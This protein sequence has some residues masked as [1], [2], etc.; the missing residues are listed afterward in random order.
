MLAPRGPRARFED[1][2]PRGARAAAR[3]AAPARAA[4][5]REPAAEPLGAHGAARAPT[6]SAGGS[7]SCRASRTSPGSSSA[8]ACTSAWSRPSRPRPSCAA[9]A[10]RALVQRV[11]RAARDASAASGSRRSAP[12]CSSCSGS[13]TTT[14][15]GRRPAGR[16]GARAARLRGRRRADE[17][18]ARRRA[19]CSASRQFTLYGDAR[20]GNRP[21]YVAAARPEHAEPLYERFCER[22]GRRSAA[23]F[24]AHM[25]GRAGQR[26]PGDA[27]ARGYA[28]GCRAPCRPTSASSAAS[29]PSRRRSR[30]PTAA[31]PR[32][33]RPSSS[34]RACGS[35]T[36]ARTSARPASSTLVPRP[37]VER[38]HV[39][40]R[41]PRATANGFELFGYV[42]FTPGD[43]RTTSR[44]TSTRW[45]DFTDETAERQPRLADGP[46]RGGRRRLARRG[47]RR[48]RR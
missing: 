18:A 42:S 3:R 48:W 37:H 23:R 20:K 41:R 8:R 32:P 15:G 31:G 21:A 36:R 44:R 33:C 17:R 10:M 45:A 29:P 24:G 43:G 35:T 46:Q 14:R 40:A 2:G 26:R 11:E 6:T 7:T 38:A 30:C 47:R 4:A 13:R 39:R 22:A 28:V 1:D 16:Q 9:D 5:R 27:A 34:R 12:A 25:D 19:R